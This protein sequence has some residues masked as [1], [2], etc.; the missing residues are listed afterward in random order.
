MANIYVVALIIIK[1][2]LVVFVIEVIAH[3]MQ[4]RE[5]FFKK[6]LTTSKN[7]FFKIFIQLFVGHFKLVKIYILSFFTLMTTQFTKLFSFI[8]ASVNDPPPQLQPGN[9]IKIIYQVN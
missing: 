5:K 4:R 9:K 8:L 6:N 2:F 1:K 7:F 3:V